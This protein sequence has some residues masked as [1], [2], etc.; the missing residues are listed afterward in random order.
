MVKTVEE[1]ILGFKSYKL[2]ICFTHFARLFMVSR[3]VKKKK[4]HQNKYDGVR[5]V[6]ICSRSYQLIYYTY[7]TNENILLGHDKAKGEMSLN[8]HLIC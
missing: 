5:F 7:L 6:F 2:K 4:N 1:I 8:T 3:C